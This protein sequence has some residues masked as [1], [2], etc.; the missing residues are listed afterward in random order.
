MKTLCEERNKQ[1]RDLHGRFSAAENKIRRLVNQLNREIDLY[2]EIIEEA[3][4]WRDEIVFE[5]EGE[6]D[7][8][9]SEARHSEEGTAY[10]AWLNAWWKADFG[11]P[12]DP[13]DAPEMNAATVMGDLPDNP[14]LAKVPS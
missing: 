13:V 9:P 7:D 6:F 11:L 2:N 5:L 1:R 12:L 4:D 10:K 14:W 8:Q 3:D